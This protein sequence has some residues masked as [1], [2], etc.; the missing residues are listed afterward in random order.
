LRT[1]LLIGQLAVLAIVVLG[2]G[3]AMYALVRQG[4]Y[5][6]A[7]SDLLGAAQSIAQDLGHGDP[8]DDLRFARPHGHRFGPGPRDFAY[9]AIWDPEGHQIAGSNPLPPHVAPL[10][11]APPLHGP[12]PFVVLANGPDIELIIAGPRNE[13]ILVGRP[14]GRERDRLWR[15]FVWLCTVGALALGVG[16][17]AAWWLAS[18]VVRPLETLTQTAEQISARRLDQR[19]QLEP[20]TAELT[21]LA[22][23]F[24]GMLNRLQTA[25]QQQVRFTADASHEL[26]TP[27]AVIL[28]QAEH[29]LSRSRSEE[30][31]RGALETCVRAARR[32]KR[33]VDDLL[34]L[35]RA[36]VGRL[37]IKAEAC[38]L[39][40]VTRAALAW[41][42]P[43]AAERQVR[44]SSQLHATHVLCDSA[45]ITQ[46]ITNL[47][48]N[49]IEY[50]R[51]GGEVF[52]TVQV[53]KNRAVL[54]VTD[55]GI[56]ISPA[57]QRRIFERFFRADPA[58][59]H[60]D[61]AGAGLGLSIVAEIIA[62]H[63]GTIDVISTAEQGTTFTVDLPL[64]QSDSP[65]TN[66][67]S[68]DL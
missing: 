51:A 24:N 23:V 59:S 15:V 41:L 64:A 45:Q 27:V 39:A 40:D 2:F 63:G 11:R 32:M 38:D 4:V 60:R 20:T 53:Q 16:G 49:A 10:E 56:G 26:R 37:E 25:F 29:T 13:Q 50:N 17:L 52:V 3:G 57:D 35:A 12:R 58:R 62:S 22:S 43:L 7:E 21:R 31:Y 48:S 33:L 5:R 47:V 54:R 55:S 34:L 30:E 61:G 14:L 65:E 46:V 8:R 18:R 1:E 9:F 67:T 66:S 6:E 19:L 68:A 36:D 28:T 42:E 44:L